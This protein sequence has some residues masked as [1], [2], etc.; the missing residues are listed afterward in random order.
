MALAGSP[1]PASAIFC[2]QLFSYALLHGTHANI[3]LHKISIITYIV[4]ISFAGRYPPPN[5]PAI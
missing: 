2:P 1:P 5:V 4:I 3:A